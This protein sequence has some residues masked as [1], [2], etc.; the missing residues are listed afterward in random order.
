MHNAIISK[1]RSINCDVRKKRIFIHWNHM[2]KM[3][4]LWKNILMF[5]EKFI[6]FIPFDNYKNFEM[7]VPLE[8]AEFCIYHILHAHKKSILKVY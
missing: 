1:V 3:F 7:K 6:C 4:T 5:F 8:V 2:D